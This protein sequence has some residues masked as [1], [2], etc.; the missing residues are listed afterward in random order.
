MRGIGHIV[1]GYGELE[2][3]LHFRLGSRWS[4][5]IKCCMRSRKIGLKPLASAS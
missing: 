2:I 4:S 5:N 3:L 1:V